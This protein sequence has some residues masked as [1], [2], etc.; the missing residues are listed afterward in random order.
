MEWVL[1]WSQILELQ[2]ILLQ[3]QIQ[4]I[5]HFLISGLVFFEMTSGQDIDLKH[6]LHI[7]S[8][9]RASMCIRLHRIHG[10]L[11]KALTQINGSRHTKKWVINL[12]D[13]CSS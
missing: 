1:E 12:C 2:K 13:M 11:I 8:M 5:W 10:A 6:L 9:F 4:F 7:F 3:L